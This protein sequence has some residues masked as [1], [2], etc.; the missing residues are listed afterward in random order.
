[1]Y[2]LVTFTTGH[3][4]KLF[5]DP[6]LAMKVCACLASA[7]AWRGASLHAWVLMPDH[8]HAV[9]ELDGTASLASVV[10]RAKAMTAMA[11]N[12]YRQVFGRVWSKTFHDRALECPL[13]V[14]YAVAYV[15]RNPVRGG[16]AADIGGYSFWGCAENLW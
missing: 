10:K 12:R 7:E 15:I 9:V 4:E 1:M 6:L 3:R 5:E 11:C 8:A 14:E 2:Y 16:I 13:A